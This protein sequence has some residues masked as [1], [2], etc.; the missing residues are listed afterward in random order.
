LCDK[1]SNIRKG[2]MPSACYCMPP[3]VRKD[4]VSVF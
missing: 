2:I 1:P 3:C 4:V